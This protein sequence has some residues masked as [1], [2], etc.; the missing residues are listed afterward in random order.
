MAL[1]PWLRRRQTEPSA[2]VVA[3]RLAV[4]AQLESVVA[5]RTSAEDALAA[6]DTLPAQT[7]RLANDA[8]HLLVHFRDDED[9]HAREPAYRENQLRGLARWV[10]RLRDE[11]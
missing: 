7:D 5:E 10:K 8:W 4:A 6:I 9:I 11:R 2:E 3:L 1:L